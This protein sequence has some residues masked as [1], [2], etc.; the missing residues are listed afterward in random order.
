[1]VF[2]E[3]PHRL[4]KTLEQ[5]AQLFGPDRMAAVARELTKLHEENARGT[6]AELVAHFQSRTVKGEIAVV[7]TGAPP[8]K[9]QK[10]GQEIDPDQET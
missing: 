10:Y 5:F 6:L 8:S 7:V 1:M 2:Y 9:K 3:S 4:V